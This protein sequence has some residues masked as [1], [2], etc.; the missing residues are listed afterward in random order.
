MFLIAAYQCYILRKNEAELR[1]KF[2]GADHPRIDVAQELGAGHAQHPF[3]PIAERQFC[4][5]IP[6]D[7]AMVSFIKW[8]LTIGQS[9]CAQFGF[10]NIDKNEASEYLK[11][12]K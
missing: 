6:T 8:I 9:Y 7:T 4:K 12:L 1:I 11:Q 2:W 5:S 3:G 10:V